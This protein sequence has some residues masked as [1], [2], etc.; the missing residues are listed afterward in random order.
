MKGK[1]SLE[2]E[3]ADVLVQLIL[4]PDTPTD[5]QVKMM[6]RLLEARRADAFFATMLREV[7]TFGACPHCAHENHW[8]I[9][10]E[11]LNKIGYVTHDRDPRIKKSTTEA[12]CARWQQAC[13]KKKVSI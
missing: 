2:E 10:E 5:L 6:S 7:V 12:D 4:D 9:P 1:R 11:E 13:G 8:L 3:N